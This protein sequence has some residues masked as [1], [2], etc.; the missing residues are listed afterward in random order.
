MFGLKNQ[1]VDK[2]SAQNITCLDLQKDLET[3]L[4]ESVKVIINV[5]AL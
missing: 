4:D 1:K 3:K 5:Y 2:F